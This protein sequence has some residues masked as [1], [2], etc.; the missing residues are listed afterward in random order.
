MNRSILA[1]VLAPAVILA[2]VSTALAQ[3]AASPSDPSPFRQQGPLTIE[4]WANLKG[5]DTATLN[6]DNCYTARAGQLQALH[7]Q[8]D[9][10]LSHQAWRTDRPLGVSTVMQAA[11]AKDSSD[12]ALFAGISL[13]NEAGYFEIELTHDYPA[14][15][16]GF[17]GGEGIITSDTFTSPPGADDTRLMPYDI[18]TPHRLSIEWFPDRH[19]VSLCADGVCHDTPTMLRGGPMRIETVV[20]S[21]LPATPNDGSWDDASYGPVTVLGTPA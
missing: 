14:K 1:C 12:Q 21:V 15:E 6:N 16:R 9:G 17:S 2:T 3:T 10:V 4:T 11:P 5:W 18:G 20:A 8:S 19:V 7:C 13:I